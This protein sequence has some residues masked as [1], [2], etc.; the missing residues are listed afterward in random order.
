MKRML[1]DAEATAE[2]CPFC[3]REIPA[4]RRELHAA[5]LDA[6]ALDCPHQDIA[7]IRDRVAARRLGGSWNRV[8]W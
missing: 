4:R 8:A 2:A 3:G 1:I 6:H 7:A 5:G